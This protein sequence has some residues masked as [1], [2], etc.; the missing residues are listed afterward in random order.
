MAEKKRFWEYSPDLDKYYFGIFTK[1]FKNTLYFFKT[2]C[3]VLVISFA[4]YV[5]GSFIY[6]FQF[7]RD[8]LMDEIRVL[9]SYSFPVVGF[10]IILFFVNLFKAPFQ[11]SKTDRKSYISE[12]D[13]LKTKIN[14]I[15]EEKI[16]KINSL[17]KELKE[18]K[19]VKLEINHKEIDDSYYEEFNSVPLKLQGIFGS[20]YP[21]EQ[22]SIR[23][24][25]I[26]IHN[27]SK[28]EKIKDIKVKLMQIEPPM[29]HLRLP[30]HLMFQHDNEKPY[31]Y[32]INLNPGDKE[33]VNVVSW[34]YTTTQRYRIFNVD[35][36]ISTF[37]ISLNNKM[38]YK[39]KIEV[40]ADKIEKITRYYFFGM[41]EKKYNEH[42]K[43][44]MW[45]AD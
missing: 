1:A 38:N 25:R 3:L 17:E 40:T 22:H 33:F 41:K 24:C 5:T 8:A 29:P 26:C 28:T 16:K 10:I 36:V 34:E 14:A 9:I 21:K 37:K 30:L 20:N 15:N 11:L 13:I 4:I 12:I 23:I 27:S 6:Y 43:I 32:S 42:E 44:Y 19:E 7:G 18:L 45:S 31:K 2:N 39:I 35:N